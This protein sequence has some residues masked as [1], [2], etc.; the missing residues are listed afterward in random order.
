[1][2]INNIGA[3][4][5]TSMVDQIMEAERA[6]LETQKG[7][8]GR[9]VEQKNEYTALSGLLSDL[10][11][12]ASGMSMPQGFSRM[13]IES[14][15]PD[16]LEGVV[17]GAALPGSYEFEVRGLAQADKHLDVG[18]PD[19][20]KTPVGFGFMEIE[21]ADGNAREIV[22]DPGSTL[23]DVAAKINDSKAG[24][25]ASIVNTGFPDDPFRLMVASE[26]TGEAAKI[27][28]D[29]DTTF[30]DFKNIKAG[31]NLD[32]AF[33]DVDVTRGDNK[34]DDLVQGVKLDAKR[35]E[36][37][38]KV[39]VDVRHDID[40]TVEGVR[41]FTAKYNKIAQFAQ[42][43]F[44]LD[45][46]TMKGGKLASDGNV[47]SLMRSL[48][49]QIASPA[50]GGSGG[51]FGSLAEVGVKTNAKTGELEVDEQ[52]LKSA[53]ATD[54]EGVANL[55]AS[56]EKGEGVAERLS[57]AVK[58]FQ[59]PT[60]GAVATRMKGLDREI[61]NQDQAIERQESRLADRETQLK[62]QFSAL[63]SRVASL[64]SQGDFLQA[65]LGGSAN[66]AGES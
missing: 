64:N 53:L 33:E 58:A 48:Q 12:A 43:Q 8:R 61:K 63:E 18:F 23:S 42:Q 3:G 47:R 66:T 15:H 17:D 32:V 26:K 2:R 29:P 20:D 21:G 62:R 24:V 5:G 50:A 6:P 22:I 11:S 34:L 59:D 54:Y 37:G 36:P 49:S 1:M 10:G 31:R 13:Q 14:S 45:P 27:N 56:S 39:T 19:V 30:L 4:V 9:I 28:I 46:S 40:K 16:I 60:H 57:K 25:R 38:T 51:K 7:R 55:F 52:K 35:A 41:D 65:K 44:Q